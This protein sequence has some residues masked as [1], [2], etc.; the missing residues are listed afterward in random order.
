[1]LEFL[2]IKVENGGVFVNVTG[3]CKII[4]SHLTPQLFMF[5]IS[6]A[7]HSTNHHYSALS[8]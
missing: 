1:M 2:L 6:K 5:E 8:F 7:F 3:F 4:L